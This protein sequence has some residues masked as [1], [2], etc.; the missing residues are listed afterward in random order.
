MTRVQ[1][2]QIQRRAEII[3][4]VIPLLNAAS[5]ED[6]SVSDICSAANIS[7]GSFYHYFERK[8]DLLVGLLGLIDSDLE[9]KVYPRLICYDE[10]DNL[11]L[12]ASAWAEY[13]DSHGIARSK[14]ISSVEPTDV[15]YT[16]QKR[17]SRS[18]LEEIMR[19]GQEKGQITAEYDAD[20]LA[21]M[22]LMAI[23]G[24]TVDW[25]RHDGSYSISD[26]MDRCIRFFLRALRC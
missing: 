25:S 11:L 13:V 10:R 6:L 3:E 9:T 5:F 16:G 26:K 12:F 20:T 23:R 7:V 1:K 21:D 2:K 14:L 8:T 19:R 24:V 22:F 17:S 18:I 4:A 15:D